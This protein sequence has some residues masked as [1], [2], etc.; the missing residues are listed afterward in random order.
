MDS[1][2][3]N[4][5]DLSCS[6]ADNCFNVAKSIPVCADASWT[7]YMGNYNPFCCTPGQIGVLPNAADVIGSG[8]CA[9]G[10][11]NVAVSA[12]ASVVCTL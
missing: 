3:S 2:W 8:V 9:Q 6:T 1:T 4:I 10:G 7:L 5:T 12:S 11:T